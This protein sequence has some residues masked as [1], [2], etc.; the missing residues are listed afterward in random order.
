MQRPSNRASLSSSGRTMRPL[1]RS[2]LSQNDQNTQLSLLERARAAGIRMSRQREL[3]CEVIDS[4]DDHPDADEIFERARARDASIAIATIYRT[5]RILEEESLVSRHDFGTGKGRFE[6]T[7]GVHHDHLI[8][9]QSRTVIEF[10]NDDLTQL[11]RSIAQQ[12]GY[13]VESHHLEVYVRERAQ[14]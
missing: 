3:V 1:K 11:I 12:M 9:T 4:A 6:V 10:Q 7:G 8:D 13:D 2:R 14:P 5:L